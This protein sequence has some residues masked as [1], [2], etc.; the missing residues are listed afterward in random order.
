MALPEHSFKGKGVGDFRGISEVLR[1]VGASEGLSF[2]C[3]GRGDR[4]V[5]CNGRGKQGKDALACVP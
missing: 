2:F 3:N 4:E 5:R 1:R